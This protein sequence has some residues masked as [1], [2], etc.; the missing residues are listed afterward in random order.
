MAGLSEVY[1][2]STAR[3]P[4]RNRRLLQLV[5]DYDQVLTS[6]DAIFDECLSQCGKTVPLRN[7]KELAEVVFNLVFTKLSCKCSARNSGHLSTLLV[8]LFGLGGEE[9][10]VV[11]RDEEGLA[12][13]LDFYDRHSPVL[14]VPGDLLSRSR[15]VDG[16]CL[17]LGPA[18]SEIDERR[19]SAEEARF[20]V[21]K[22]S[23]DDF[24]VG[25]DAAVSVRSA[26]DYARATAS[27]EDLT[28]ERLVALRQGCGATAI[29]STVKFGE[30]ARCLAREVGID[31]LF[32]PEEEEVDRLC[33]AFGVLPLT[34]AG[35]SAQAASTGL[36]RV[37]IFSR[38]SSL[39]L[40]AKPWGCEA[41]IVGAKT[42]VLCS[43]TPAHHARLVRESL[44]VIASSV[45]EGAVTTVPGACAM[46]R[47]LLGAIG[48]ALREGEVVLGASH[49]LGLEILGIMAR[50]TG[51]ACW[52]R[53]G[54][55]ESGGQAGGA[56]SGLREGE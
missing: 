53:S 17:T 47:R 25:S 55:G 1:R 51:R 37:L 24:S 20:I 54:A 19:D 11:E 52:V 27:F 28:R 4:E 16:V 15:I 44:R 9:S 35:P 48:A 30:R 36:A 49:R 3:I 42:L 21:T 23:L 38:G 40:A 33:A 22:C 12:S 45:S 46:E 7:R 43:P 10:K 31:L 26:H 29:V 8:S 39:I 2:P 5:Q 32:C 50:A 14:G 34:E 6:F 56:W 41:A 18:C 13:L